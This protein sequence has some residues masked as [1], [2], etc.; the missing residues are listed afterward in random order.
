[1][2][3][4]KSIQQIRAENALAK[5]ASARISKPAAEPSRAVRAAEQP[6]ESKQQKPQSYQ[7]SNGVVATVD[8]SQL[9]QH[10][11]V[12]DSIYAAIDGY[13]LARNYRSQ[14]RADGRYE[15]T[16]SLQYGEI[17]N[18]SFAR[19]IADSATS[20]F[21]TIHA[22]SLHFVDIGAGTGKAVAA[23]AL[24][25]YFQ[26][27]SGF[28]IV[29]SLCQAADQ[30]VRAATSDDHGALCAGKGAHTVNGTSSITTYYRSCVIDDPTLASDGVAGLHE[31]DCTALRL[32]WT[33]ADVFFAP[34]TCFEVET[35]HKVVREM[36]AL[37][38]AGALVITTSIM[39]RLDDLALE[40]QVSDG[41]GAEQKGKEKKPFKFL[42]ER[43]IRYG[44]GTMT[45][46]LFRKQ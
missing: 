19:L 1:M 40:L 26:C 8:N 23:A 20:A 14:L 43:R 22:N 10:A 24:T 18:Y 31:L 34:I 5:A 36:T 33:R 16:E 29:P 2:V 44:K 4:R 25:G 12:L 38:K 37:I 6:R 15:E 7:S 13:A 39:T 21:G 35:L 45:F 27:C 32:H 41:D 3:R 42:E 46:F 17:D 28:E 9:E 30:A 11:L